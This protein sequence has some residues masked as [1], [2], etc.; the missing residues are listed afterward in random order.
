MR[1]VIVGR[2]GNGSDEFALGLSPV[3]G[4]DALNPGLVALVRGIRRKTVDGKIFRRTMIAETV[5][6]IDAQS[7]DIGDLLDPRQLGF[8]LAERPFR[9]TQRFIKPKQLVLAFAQRG[10]GADHLGSATATI[11][12]FGDLAD[13]DRGATPVRRIRI[14]G[15]RGLV[16][17]CLVLTH[18]VLHTLKGY[19]HPSYRRWRKKNQ[20][21]AA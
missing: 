10:V 8:T 5:D 12:V 20:S 15:C 11:F 2:S 13:P 7:A 21:R 19:N 17:S 9:F 16:R 14:D 6:K 18:G 4:V 3:V 1:L